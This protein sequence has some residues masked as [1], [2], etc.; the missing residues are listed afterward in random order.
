MLATGRVRAR[1]KAFG[2]VR[3]A[4]QC[5]LS[6][7]DGTVPDVGKRARQRRRHQAR[8]TRP[9]P[10]RQSPRQ[11]VLSPAAQ[12]RT[13]ANGREGLAHLDELVQTRRRVE[14]QIDAHVEDLAA[15]GVSWPAIADVLGVSRQAARQAHLRRRTNTE[16]Q[17]G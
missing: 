3:S 1:G 6:V 4:R 2:N 17:K 16:A 14:E 13:A 10:S 9:P 7:W 5:R 15:A 11:H 12:E 8:Q